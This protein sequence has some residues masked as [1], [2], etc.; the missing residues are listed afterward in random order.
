MTLS[1]KDEHLK[2]K[3]EIH[4]KQRKRIMNEFRD[5]YTFFSNDEAEIIDGENGATLFALNGSKNEFKKEDRIFSDGRVYDVMNIQKH[6]LAD[7]K[8]KV[9]VTKQN[10]FETQIKKLQDFGCHVEYGVTRP[11]VQRDYA[12]EDYLND[13]VGLYIKNIV[14]HYDEIKNGHKIQELQGLFNHDIPALC[15]GAGPSLDANVHLV[16]EFPGIVISTDKSFKMLLARNIIPDFVISVD[17][18]PNIISDM[19]RV[20]YGFHTKLIL[21]SSSDPEISKHWKGPIFYYNM[22]HYGV[23]FM[24]KIL[25]ALFPDLHGIINS[26]NVGNSSVLFA[27]YIGLSPIVMIGHDYAYTGGRMHAQRFEIEKDGSVREI[28][29]DHEKML[30][31]RTG[32]VKVGDNETYVPFLNYRETLYDLRS[33]RGFDIINSTEGGILEEIPNIKFQDVIEGLKPKIG[34]RYVEARHKINSI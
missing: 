24:D 8:F 18:H 15:V 29:D 1:P 11:I 27:D 30:F 12:S 9:A 5:I 7:L 22:I 33:K 10:E 4:R 20:P 17:C 16:H 19:L 2:T 26:G 32:K 25:P 31:E 14:A 28:R 34:D 3:I 21:N 23:Q 6:E 13:W